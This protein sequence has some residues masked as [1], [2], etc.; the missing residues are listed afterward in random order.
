MNYLDLSNRVVN[1]VVLDLQLQALLNKHTTR[2]YANGP[3]TFDR[4]VRIAADLAIDCWRLVASKWRVWNCQSMS[5]ASSD[6]SAK[7]LHRE[8]T[9]FAT[10]SFWRLLTALTQF[11]RHARF[12]QWQGKSSEWTVQLELKYFD[13]V[14]RKGFGAIEVAIE[15]CIN[16]LLP[17]EMLIALLIC[18][19]LLLLFLLIV[20]YFVVASCPLGSCHTC[21][22][23]WAWRMWARACTASCHF[24]FELRW[25]VAPLRCSI[26][27]A[28]IA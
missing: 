13:Q 5:I 15:L 3:N 28:W 2:V 14:S 22:V 1:S 16:L 23:A 21:G 19:T 7:L 9:T 26:N 18:S 4:H 20:G 27:Y 10:G 17:E 25:Q 6:L 12:W 8:R 11:D 24:D